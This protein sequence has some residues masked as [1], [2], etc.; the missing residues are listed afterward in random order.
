MKRLLTIGLSLYL[1]LVSILPAALWEE[2]V[3]LPQLWEHYQLH[4]QTNPELALT[5]F[6]SMHYGEGSPKHQNQH[7]HSQIPFKATHHC[8]GVSWHIA[9]IP[10]PSVAPLLLHSAGFILSQRPNFHYNSVPLTER[11]FSF[12]HPPKM[13]VC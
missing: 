2:C 6:I 12:F 8:L 9:F 7:D 3:K 1:S 10:I 13:D 4:C 11:T 5:E